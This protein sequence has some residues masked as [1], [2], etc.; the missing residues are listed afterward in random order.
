MTCYCYPLLLYIYIYVYMYSI[1]SKLTGCYFAGIYSCD[2]QTHGNQE[3]IFHNM[4]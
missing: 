4:D 3:E 2:K 1:D